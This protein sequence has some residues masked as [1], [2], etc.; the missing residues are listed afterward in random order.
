[1]PARI[2]ETIPFQPL[3]IAVLTA[4]DSRNLAT[5]RSGDVLVER[6]P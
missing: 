4:S 2:D 1:M 3:R 5:D 6:L